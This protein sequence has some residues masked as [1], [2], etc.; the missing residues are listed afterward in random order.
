MSKGNPGKCMIALAAVI[1][2]TLTGSV[3]AQPLC[4]QEIFVDTTLTGDLLGCPG[5]GLHIRA[6]NVVLDCNGHTIEAAGHRVVEVDFGLSSVTVKNCVLVSTANTDALRVNEGSNNILITNNDISTSGVQSRGIRLNG[7]SQSTVSGNS[8]TTSGQLS[9]AIRFSFSSNNVAIGNEVSTS[10]EGARGF[11]IDFDSVN[12]AV[13]GNMVHTT[14]AGSNGARLRAGSD[15]NSFERNVLRSDNTHPIR[16][17][18]ASNNV[19]REN[20]LAS[21]TD[22]LLSRRFTL[23]NG[24][25]SVHPDGRIFAVENI[26]GGGGGGFGV[27]T[28]TAFFEVEPETGA[29][30]NVIRL[31]LADF[32]LG[33][34]F[35]ALEITPNGRFLALRGGSSGELY[36][37]DPVTGEVTFLFFL[38]SVNGLESI[39]NVSLLATSNTGRLWRIDL[40]AR[41]AVFI[42]N[43]F[44]GWT[45][46]AVDPVSGAAYALSRHVIENSATNHLFE[47]DV[48]TGG[49]IREIGDTGEAFVSD[50]DFTGDG[51]LYGNVGELLAI[52]SATAASQSVGAF[53]ED[54]FE[55]PSENNVLSKTTLVAAGGSGSVHYPDLLAVPFPQQVDVTTEDLDIGFNRVFV[56]SGEHPF[57]NQE[58]VITLL[59]L[60][61]KKRRLLVDEDDDGEFERCL[62]RQCRLREFEGGT[63]IFEVDG[64]TTYS[65]VERRRGRHLIDS[66]EDD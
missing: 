31:T 43:S 51:V 15:G 64:F 60:P 54:P 63:L 62:G 16:I 24:G 30:S 53:G 59:G 21:A 27:G 20:T 5:R 2:A 55:P 65:S 23:Q 10:G 44:R 37:I 47:I 58:A 42:G 11:L 41:A 38:P 29:A 25:L 32:D 22:W 66:D 3:A 46:I 14:R 17:E 49:I 8:V 36:E 18:S 48:S 52:D 6:S 7:T 61:G 4:G 45:D 13:Q 28:A 34:G 56:D 9:D 19:F 26:F 39:D 50:M 12:N 1:S 33:L 35:D 57:L 40:N